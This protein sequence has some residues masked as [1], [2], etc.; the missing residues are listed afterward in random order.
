MGLRTVVLA[1]KII[2]RNLVTDKPSLA[3]TL[4][5]DEQLSTAAALLPE[6]WWNRSSS[7]ELS[8]LTPSNE[9]RERVL[10][11][12]YFFHVRLYLHLPFMAKSV[13]TSTSVISKMACMEASRQML[14]RFLLLHST[15]QGPYL[16]ECK[17]TAFLSFMAAVILI[18]GLDDLGHMPAPPSSEEDMSL[19][20]GVRNIFHQ[21]V[22]K[23][24]SKISSQCFNALCTLMKA[25]D[26]DLQTARLG[27]EPE[28]KIL[29]PYFGIVLRRRTTGTNTPLVPSHTE[30]HAPFDQGQA[31]STMPLSGSGLLTGP[32]SEVEPQAL[33]YLGRSMNSPM[34][35][36]TE[37]PG[38]NSSLN[39][40]GDLMWPDPLM[41][42][43]D[44]DWNM[45][46]NFSNA[47]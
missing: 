10:L 17:T 24:G 42:D 12:F 34:L 43:L 32:F 40:L 47:F 15:T 35:G 20:A 45:L 11:Q 37:L 9:L 39:A 25:Q 38:E 41:M 4:S 23:D 33:E 27:E 30:T 46:T 19:L 3:E 13:T 31:S 1:G 6:D 8:H 44:H 5:L 36:P 21:T 28:K 18:L 22:K 7:E 26:T 14:K 2:E 16:F 29:I